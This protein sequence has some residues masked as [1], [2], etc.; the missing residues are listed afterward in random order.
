[1]SPLT[2]HDHLLQPSFY[3][4]VQLRALLPP[5]P[6]PHRTFSPSP[7]WVSIR[8]C[9]ALP[10]TVLNTGEHPPHSKCLP[11]SSLFSLL[12]PCLF[13]SHSLLLPKVF[14]NLFHG[15]RQLAGMSKPLCGYIC[16]VYFALSMLCD[17]KTD[18]NFRPLCAMVGV[19]CYHVNM[20]FYV[21]NIRINS[22]RFLSH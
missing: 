7:D 8:P 6:P 9:L 22:T 12:F 20:H 3:P 18:G 2:I 19:A 14:H 15:L 4:Y 16:D 13:L 21:Q 17:V 1:M 10:L 5:P 11:H